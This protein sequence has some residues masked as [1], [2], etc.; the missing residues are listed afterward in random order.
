MQAVYEKLASNDLGSIV[1]ACDSAVPF[2]A[3]LLRDWADRGMHVFALHSLL[4][5]MQRLE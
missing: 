1:E 2:L 3:G 5:H 4:L